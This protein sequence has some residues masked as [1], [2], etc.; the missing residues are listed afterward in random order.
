MIGVGGVM[1][2]TEGST[3]L[4]EISEAIDGADAR[5]PFS[6]RC[7]VIDGSFQLRM[8]TARR[9]PPLPPPPPSAAR[10]S[11]VMSISSLFAPEFTSAGVPTSPEAIVCASLAGSVLLRAALYRWAA[12]RHLLNAKFLEQAAAQCAL[13]DAEE[14]Y[15]RCVGQEPGAGKLWT[16]GQPIMQ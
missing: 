14:M 8:T 16:K 10:K 9:P 13:L 6:K 2:G 3:V 5:L 12:G 4:K 15:T 7:G 1:I 11:L